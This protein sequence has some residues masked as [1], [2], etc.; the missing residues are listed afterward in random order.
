MTFEELKRK[1][2]VMWGTGTYDR[3]S[4]TVADVH[5]ALVSGLR[6][7]PGE[8][9]LDL[10]TGT[11]QVAFRAARAGAAVTGLDLAPAL[12]ETAQRL[13]AENGL[14]IRFDAGDAE[15]LPYEDASF[16]VV[17]SSFGAMFA[18]DHAAV[19][20][21]LARVCRPV[22]R[23]GLATWRPDGGVGDLFRVMAP[24]Q[25]PP[26]TGVGDPFDWGREDYLADLL[27]NWFDLDF[28]EGDNR[29]RATSGEE[30][31][32]LF[33]SSYGPTRMLA[34]SL[35]PQRREEFRRA[36]VDYY[37]GSRVDGGIDNSR[38]YLLTFGRRH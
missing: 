25:A 17:S 32:G 12:L 13:A 7:Q 21:E 35:D 1:Q 23:L 26:P 31:W 3:I 33:Y 8:P 6:P 9:W 37:E 20:R 29:L 16:D 36:F 4:Q 22:G 15:H 27:G 30:V 11:G 34:D 19:A 18:P 38:T 10:A 5:E 14:S 28:V 2:S 24:F